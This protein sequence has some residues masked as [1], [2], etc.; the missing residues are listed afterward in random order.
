MLHKR[1]IPVTEYRRQGDNALA[2]SC[3]HSGFVLAVTVK[4]TVGGEDNL[5]GRVFLA[6]KARQR[7]EV[8]G[9]QRHHN[10]FTCQ[11][12]HGERGRIA[13]RYP[14]AFSGLFFS[15]DGVAR[16]FYRPAFQGAFET[17]RTDKLKVNQCAGIVIQR[18]NHITGAKRHS[19]G[20]VC[21]RQYR[22]FPVGEALAGQVGV[23]AGRSGFLHEPDG[24]CGRRFAVGIGFSLC[25]R[26]HFRGNRRQV[27]GHG[28][29]LPGS[30]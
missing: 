10:G 4:V 12:M 1:I 20:F 5:T 9:R 8:H 3:G 6:D 15:F 29:H 25:G 18:D 7:K 24:Q 28:V 13:L 19:A 11:V 14:Q 23:A 21:G 27:A 22:T 16:S 26:N 30:L 17:V 2:G